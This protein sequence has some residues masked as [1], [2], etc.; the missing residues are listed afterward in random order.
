VVIH[1]E[2]RSVAGSDSFNAGATAVLT[3]TPHPTRICGDAAAS[4]VTLVIVSDQ[5]AIPEL[6]PCT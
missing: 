4:E 6:A 3:R 1:T 2:W 5:T